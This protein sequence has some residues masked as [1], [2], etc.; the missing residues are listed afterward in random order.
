[1]LKIL[2]PLQM[3]LFLQWDNKTPEKEPYFISRCRIYM[4]PPLLS[5]KQVLTVTA[6]INHITLMP[7]C[8]KV[9]PI[10]PPSLWHRTK[11]PTKKVLV[12]T[13]HLC[14]S[15]VHSEHIPPSQGFLQAIPHQQYFLQL[16]HCPHTIIL[17][18]KKHNLNSTSRIKTHSRNRE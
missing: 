3:S 17:C 9:C 16:K 11:S 18:F 5:T 12:S 4:H 13:V 6:S 2:T 8:Q 14:S 7:S 1:M 10:L 15:T